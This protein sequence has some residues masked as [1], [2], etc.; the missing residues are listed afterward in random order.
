MYVYFLY[1]TRLMMID[2]S[3]FSE[4]QICRVDQWN[5][6]DEKKTNVN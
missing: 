5:F 3:G 6:K 1:V 4:Y 2:R